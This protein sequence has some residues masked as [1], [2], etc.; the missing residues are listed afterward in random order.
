MAF[1]SQ[2]DGKLGS[3]R[4]SLQEAPATVLP[5]T[6][7]LLPSPR[8]QQVWTR[9]SSGSQDLRGWNYALHGTKAHYSASTQ[10][11]PVRLS[12]GSQ[13]PEPTNRQTVL[14]TVLAHS[15]HLR[16][17]ESCD[18]HVRLRLGLRASWMRGD[19]RD[20]CGQCSPKAIGSTAGNSPH[21]DRSE[22]GVTA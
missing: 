21:K 16:V 20:R 5:D 4:L 11:T 14:P 2:P 1:G 7:T 17:S 3:P 9:I 18:K 22:V 10:R 8:S 12:R 19:L 6:A 13:V 15:R